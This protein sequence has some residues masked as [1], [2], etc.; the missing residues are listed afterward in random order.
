MVA[1]SSFMPTEMGFFGSATTAPSASFSTAEDATPT[2]ITPFISATS[3]GTLT[4]ERSTALVTECSRIATPYHAAGWYEALRD[5]NLLDRYPNL[6]HDITYG[7]PIGNP[8]APLSTFLPPN[9]LMVIFVPPRSVSWRRNQGSEN[10][11]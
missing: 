7:S 10:G 9:M 5:C 4:T 3:A 6:I 2:A 11:G 8:P 1:S